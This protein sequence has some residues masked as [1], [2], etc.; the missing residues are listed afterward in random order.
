MGAAD[1]LG[2]PSLLQDLDSKNDFIQ[3]GCSLLHGTGMKP[4]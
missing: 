4:H 1:L 2:S 3:D